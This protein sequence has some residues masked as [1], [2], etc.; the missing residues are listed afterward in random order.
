MSHFCATSFQ[1]VPAIG[2]PEFNHRERFA[3]ERF[4]EE[5]LGSIKWMHTDGVLGCVSGQGG[6]WDNRRVIRCMGAGLMDCIVI[7]VIA[8]AGG[9]GI[10]DSQGR[11]DS[12]CIFVGT[13][14]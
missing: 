8:F 2:L 4:Q 10:S 14:G 11:T 12:I 6:I 9:Y 13:V 3:V 5:D 1:A 7:H